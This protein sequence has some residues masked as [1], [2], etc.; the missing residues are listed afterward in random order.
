[1]H[2]TPVNHGAPDPDGP[3]LPATVGSAFMFQNCAVKFRPFLLALL[4]PL[5]VVV[6]V[7][8]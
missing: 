1:V 5:H 3:E 8:Q 6:A 4:P 7:L 2:A